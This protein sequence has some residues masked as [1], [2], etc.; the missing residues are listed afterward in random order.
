MGS[1]LSLPACVFGKIKKA[2]A[3]DHAGSKAL[4]QL[5]V[6][7]FFL[8]HDCCFEGEIRIHGMNGKLERTH[9]QSNKREIKQ[10]THQEIVIFIYLFVHIFDYV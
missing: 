9:R 1:V 6:F 8:F 2:L 10:Y 5:E 3:V 4:P 7:L